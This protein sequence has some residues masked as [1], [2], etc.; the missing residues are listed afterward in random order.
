MFEHSNNTAASMME[1]ECDAFPSYLRVLPD[2]R[3]VLCTT[4]GCCYTRQW[5]SR[6]LLEQHR[7]KGRRRQR[8]ESSS[9]LN[10]IAT[11][12][13]DVVQPQDG[14]N[15][16]R[17]LPTV[18]GF[19]CH[20]PDCDFR[21]TSSDRIR[22]HY[23]KVHQWK[24]LHQGAMP[25]NEAYVQ[26]LFQQTQSQHYFAVVLADQAHPSATPQYIYPRA[27]APNNAAPA[28]TRNDVQS[29]P[30]TVTDNELDQMMREYHADLQQE[31][32]CVETARDVSEHTP[33]MKRT[34][35][36][37]HLLGLERDELGPSCY[38]PGVQEEPSLFL[39][40]ESIG[41]V[42]EKAMNALTHNR[43]KIAQTL[44]RHEARLLNTFTRREISPLDYITQLQNPKS[45]QTY[46]ETWQRL[47]C[48][49][50]R[51]VEQS[52]LRDTLFQP[53]DR[54][55]EAWCKATDAASELASPTDPDRD[56]AFRDRLDRAVLEFSLAI[57]QHSVPR[58]KF[59]SVLVS[60]AAV[61]FWSH[62]QG[63]WMPVRN[64]TSILSQLIYDCQMVVLAQVLA[65]AGDNDNADI[66]AMIVDIRDQWLLN[67]TDGPVVELLEN[68]VLSFRIGQTEVQPPQIHWRADGETL[69]WS[70]VILHLSDL[71]R[72]IFEGVADARRIFDEE[73]CL[74][75]RSSPACDIPGL[76]LR[77]L[78]DNWGD[79]KHGQ[80]FLTDSRNAAYVDPL[81]DWVYSRVEKS[82]AL[83]DTFWLETDA[84]TCVV[85]A[86]AVQQYEDAVQRFLRAL[87][88]PFF[89]GSGQQGRQ[90]DFIGLKWR[91]TDYVPRNL[92]LLGGQML[93]TLSNRMDQARERVFFISFLVSSLV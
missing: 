61:R 51:V 67:D 1:P 86:D 31:Q 60:Y 45:L 46:I 82:Q 92:F 93:F 62:K 91:N 56:E 84:N 72:I 71:H 35:I 47:I 73:L 19:L 81:N 11:S 13:T 70:D 4:H 40:C 37:A 5:L 58:R 89:L 20:L 77:L 16:I 88:V 76:D 29:S 65:M 69:V 74:S 85:R 42:L 87:M 63:S 7:L 52:H 44:R 27:N 33:W 41:R 43:N 48:Y 21:S 24:V 75:S 23:N 83:Y 15:E 17:G 54:Q 2:L 64:Y 38:L 28:S 32:D 12:N 53:S 8:I 59:D 22:M 66:G 18:L 39:I 55:L 79:R 6:H 25:W 10:D 36:Y 78:V 3:V 80:S 90:T 9:R 49:W 57:I 50:H 34:G 14:T 30:P 68:W 26:T